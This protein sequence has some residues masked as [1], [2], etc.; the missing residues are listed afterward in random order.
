LGCERRGANGLAVANSLT[1]AVRIKARI[2]LNSQDGQDRASSRHWR[3]E[4]FVPTRVAAPFSPQKTHL[5]FVTLAGMYACSST[6]VTVLCIFQFPALIS[7][8]AFFISNS[9]KEHNHRARLGPIG[10]AGNWLCCLPLEDVVRRIEGCVD[11]AAP[12]VFA[13]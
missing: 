9:R 2:D 6:A 1:L 13:C 10:I 5:V 4:Q 8:H 3:V 7:F 12:W 11:P